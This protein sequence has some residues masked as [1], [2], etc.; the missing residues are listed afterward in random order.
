[1]KKS[2]FLRKIRIDVK[3]FDEKSS[4]AG[5]IYDNNDDVGKVHFGV[6]HLIDISGSRLVQ[7]NEECISENFWAWEKEN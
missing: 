3:E 5:V 4:I 2:L 7:P 1:L 6:V